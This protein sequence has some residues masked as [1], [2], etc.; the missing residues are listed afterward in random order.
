MHFFFNPG[1]RVLVIQ[2][3]LGEADSAFDNRR[4]GPKQDTRELSGLSISGKHSAGAPELPRAKA[5]YKMIN[6]SEKAAYAIVTMIIKP[7]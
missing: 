7:E 2:D 1:Y 4:A 5:F 6:C 3:A